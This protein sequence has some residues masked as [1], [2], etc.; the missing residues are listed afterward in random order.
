MARDLDAR[1]HE[2]T[3]AFGLSAQEASDALSRHAETV[4]ARLAETHRAV[5]AEH[6][7]MGSDV[8]LARRGQREMRRSRR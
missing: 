4:G 5:A 1:R 2:L 3:L 6:V 7:A 8:A